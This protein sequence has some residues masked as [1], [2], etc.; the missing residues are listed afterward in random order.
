MSFPLPAFNPFAFLF[1]GNSNQNTVTS[2]NTPALTNTNTNQSLSAKDLERARILNNFDKQ[3]TCGAWT[4]RQLTRSGGC[5]ET[6]I[7][8]MQYLQ[9][10]LG[11][12][13]GG[14]FIGDLPADT[15]LKGLKIQDLQAAFD[16]GDIK[17]GDIITTTTQANLGLSVDDLAAGGKNK[18]NHAA[19]V[20]AV[21]NQNTGKYEI[22]L[23]DND[24]KTAK[25]ST[26]EEYINFIGNY[27]PVV[28][29]VQKPNY[30]IRNDSTSR[31][32]TTNNRSLTTA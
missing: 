28:H 4:G 20:T 5:V 15:K 26:L 22:R 10:E 18:N 11:V 24:S 27:S 16:R 7:T 30:E 21:F 12:A 9:K 1:E 6:A 14:N 32:A 25:S 17:P 8:A 2:N 19:M 13:S 23:I 31:I 29:S 3:K